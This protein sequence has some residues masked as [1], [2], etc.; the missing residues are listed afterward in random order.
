MRL[1]GTIFNR[2]DTVWGPLFKNAINR[3][4]DREYYKFHR[5]QTEEQKM[6]SCCYL[7]Q[8]AYENIM[9]RD[10]K[11]FLDEFEITNIRANIEQKDDHF[12]LKVKVDV[13][14]KEIKKISATI[15][16]WWR[17]SML[18]S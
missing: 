7:V 15:A 16:H 14:S 1:N 4:M 8:T 10:G 6:I 5:I 17:S 11:R 2:L 9:L 12:I 18:P 3:V 13:Q